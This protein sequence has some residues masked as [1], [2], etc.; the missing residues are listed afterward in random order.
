[1]YKPNE[2][3]MSECLEKGIACSFGF[4]ADCVIGIGEITRVKEL[5]LNVEE[6][7]SSNITNNNNTK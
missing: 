4:C 3:E 5:K 6:T 7:D 2:K 1:M